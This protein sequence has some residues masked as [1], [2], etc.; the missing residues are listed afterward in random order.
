MYL[1]VWLQVRLG[2]GVFLRDNGSERKHGT[3]RTPQ[4]ASVY[5]RSIIIASVVGEESHGTMCLI[6]QKI[7]FK[8]VGTFT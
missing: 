4:L 6:T 1:V 2:G 8:V 3:V 7:Q 5:V